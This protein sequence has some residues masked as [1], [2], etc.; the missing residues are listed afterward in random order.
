VES[1]PLGRR[2]EIMTGDHATHSCIFYLPSSIFHLPSSIFYLL[3]SIFYLL[4][5]ISHLQN[6][7]HQ[8][9]AVVDKTGVELD[10]LLLPRRFLAFVVFGLP[11]LRFISN[12]N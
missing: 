4:S 11:S 12:F 1:A 7:P 9:W 6:L 8:W 2:G 10:E 5:S 3:S